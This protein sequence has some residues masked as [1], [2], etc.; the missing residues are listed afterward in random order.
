[1]RGEGGSDDSGVCRRWLAP[2]SRALRE[3]GRAAAVTRALARIMC[4]EDRN[5]DVTVAVPLQL[6]P[7]DAHQ[8]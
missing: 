5:S 2:L 7:N 4:Q 8:R 3:C 6:S 1:M